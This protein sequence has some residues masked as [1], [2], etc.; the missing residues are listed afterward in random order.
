MLY[1]LALALAFDLQHER[2]SRS[3]CF[4]E[5]LRGWSDHG[6]GP[7]HTGTS[8]LNR[9][10]VESTLPFM[11]AATTKKRSE[12]DRIF[13]RIG[14]CFGNDRVGRPAVRDCGSGWRRIW[15]KTSISFDGR[16]S[17]FYHIPYG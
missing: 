15:E 7:R 4:Q 9:E 17:T 8:T 16:I 5:L 1:L 13:Y 6:R 12:E 14:R 3:A 11:Q 10:G 2:A